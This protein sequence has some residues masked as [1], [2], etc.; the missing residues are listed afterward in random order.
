MKLQRRNIQALIKAR[1]RQG[2]TGDIVSL[3]DGTPGMCHID[4]FG[5]LWT[6]S[7]S[8]AGGGG[9]PAPAIGSSFSIFSTPAAATQ[10]TA[11]QP[12]AGA[13]ARNVITSLAWTVG[14]VAAQAV[15]TLVVR[16]GASGVGPII[17]AQT[18]GPLAA[19]GQLS[20]QLPGL[21]ITGSLNT[22]MTVEFTAAPAATNFESVAATGYNS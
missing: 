14:A 19:A 16:D 3:N 21:N 22:D 15:L 8:G 18:V 20:G 11:T 6:V 7:A 1:T 9:S 5:N 10:A 12:A 2:P 17:W 4:R 13:T